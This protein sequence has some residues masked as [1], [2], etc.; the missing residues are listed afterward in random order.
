MISI[1]LI[2]PMLVHFPIVLFLG[3]VAAG[4]WVLARGADLSGRE[5]L[6]EMALA[7]L[8]L[9]LMFAC[10]AAV[11]GDI[12]MDKAVS[13]GFPAAPIERHETFAMTTLGLFAFQTVVR[14]FAFWKH[15]PLAKVRGWLAEIPG[16]SGAACLIA[17]A[18]YGGELVY[19]FGVNVAALP[20]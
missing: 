19:H 9:G 20:R 15:I 7:F 12:A 6:P 14:L 1:A 5:Y 16:F 2:H 4:C 17:T 3:A 10:L 13:A 8:I 11:F 18:Y